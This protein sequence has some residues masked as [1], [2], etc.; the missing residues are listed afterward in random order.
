MLGKRCAGAAT[1]IWANRSSKYAIR[2]RVPFSSLSLAIMEP[3]RQSRDGSS[4]AFAAQFAVEDHTRLGR[5]V[6]AWYPA[7]YCSPRFQRMAWED[8]DLQNADDALRLK[9][10]YWTM[11]GNRSPRSTN[12]PACFV[13]YSGSPHPR[14]V[15]SSFATM[16]SRASRMADAVPN[17][18][19]LSTSPRIC[20]V[21][22]GKRSTVYLS[23]CSE[24]SAMRSFL[25]ELSAHFLQE[26]SEWLLVAN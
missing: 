3:L 20:T 23:G 18:L 16:D 26:F 21:T 17:C 10:Q 19:A 24:D 14:G 5:A 6:K 7:H 11:K 1:R 13:A 25:N 15:V 22:S 2:V 8:T 4:R 12:P 9:G